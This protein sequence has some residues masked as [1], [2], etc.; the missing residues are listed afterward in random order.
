M[1][2]SYCKE[3][4]AL[5]GLLLNEPGVV[6]SGKLWT[7]EPSNIRF[8]YGESLAELKV[9]Y[10]LGPN[11]EAC[12]EDAVQGLAGLLKNRYEHG[13]PDE[14]AEVSHGARQVERPQLRDKSYSTDVLVEGTL[15]K[16]A[17]SDILRTTPFLDGAIL[18]SWLGPDGV[19]KKF[20]KWVDG[21]VEK[22][23][24]EEAKAESGERT[25]YLA[26]LAMIKS[27]RGK[28]EKIR[29]LRIKG[30]SYEKLDLT[31]SSALFMAFRAAVW[32]LLERLKAEEAHYYNK[33]AEVILKTALVP[34]A[35]LSIPSTLLSGLL[36]P[37]GISW[38]TFQAVS[39]HI[40]KMEEVTANVEELVKD[41]ARRINKQKALVEAIRNQHRIVTLRE[42]IIDYLMEFDTPGQSSHKLL[43]ELYQEDHHLKALLND[44]KMMDRLQ[45][46]LNKIKL[47][48][49]RDRERVE[50]VESI[51][52]LLETYKKGKGWFKAEKDD[53][54]MDLTC[55]FAASL[56][57]HVE[58]YA[59]HMRVYLTDRRGEFDDKMLYEDYT[60]GMLYR[61]SL[62]E[63]PIIATLRREE[64]AQLFV[65]MKDFTR[66]TL[67]VKEVVMAE[68]MKENFYSP[69]LD[70]ASRYGAGSGPFADERGIRLNSLPGD[71]AIFSGGITNL[72]ALAHDI[73]KIIREYRG[74]LSRR[75]P[76]VKDEVILGEVHKDFKAKKAEFKNRRTALEKA[77]AGG[78]KE[79]KVKLFQ[80]AEQEQRADKG[81]GEE[82]EAAIATEIE[83]GL[84]ISYGGKAET[85]LIEGKE[86]FTGQV[87]VA[88]GEKIN[89][90]ARGTFRNSMVRAKLE[91]HLENERLKRNNMLLRYP[92]DIYI[93]STF[94][95]RMTPEIDDAIEGLISGRSNTDAKAIAEFVATK[96]YSDLKKLA[97][98]VPFSSLR[99]LT[100][101]TDIYNKGRAITKE[102]LEA[103]IKDTKG[104]SFFFKKAV[105]A[106]KLNKSFQDTF[107]FPTDELELWFGVEVKKAVETVEG[108]LRSGEVV[109]KGFE[110]AKPT[111]VYEILD[112]EGPFFK[113][114][115]TYH[116]NEWLEGAKK[117][118]G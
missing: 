52:E 1:T 57:E 61:F 103:Y 3:R 15:E 83:A 2:E 111:V 113:G 28:K 76:P 34:K 7:L 59:G 80:L 6:A 60:R 25:S 22:A 32:A 29:G 74:K 104:R 109:F 117:A 70:A 89:E 93:D 114:L 13:H 86:D 19:G 75:L 64:E 108:F 62:D 78:D 33:N 107:F 41:S 72:V 43:Y 16:S 21:M 12:I 55:F 69:I 37:Y 18:I 54:G 36:N 40:P 65:D 91:M 102:A 58:K 112:N 100:S 115:Q 48:F 51:L 38:E 101:T 11:D 9:P 4:L 5:L 63:R 85:M 81:Y 23:L 27:V 35:F 98:G 31:I 73:E 97:K 45:A 77:L 106:S 67:K 44:R 30:I 56:D 84:F 94:S 95:L 87:K 46:A 68:F 105:K 110:S 92:F 47:N 17:A 82:L 53:T 118:Q 88:I 20:I 50:R 71:A 90:A 8:R 79:A 14:D 39:A 42:H 24:M 99:L 10:H 116:F 66:K 26:L 49:S 96:Y